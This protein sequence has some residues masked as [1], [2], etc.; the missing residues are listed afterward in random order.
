MIIHKKFD[1]DRSNI[2]SQYFIRVYISMVIL[3]TISLLS[4]SCAVSDTDQKDQ[5]LIISDTGFEKRLIELGIDSEGT[6]DQQLL[7]IDAKT[8]TQLD[9]SWTNDSEVIRDLTGIEGFVN[10]TKLAVTRQEVEQIDL[11]SNIQLDT[12]YL[13]GNNL[14]HIDLSFN[15]NLT[16]VNLGTN[17]LISV[18]GLSE[19]NKLKKLDLSLNY[20]DTFAI[21]NTSVETLF[22]NLNE[23]QSLDVSEAENLKSL[24]LTSNQLTNLSIHNNTKLETLLI[25]NNR[26]QQLELNQNPELQY[27][28]ASN[29]AFTNLDVSHNQNLMDLRIDQNPSLNCIT[30]G[31]AQ[32][33]LMVRKSA[34]QELRSDCGEYKK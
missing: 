26:M 31:Q 28:Y 16:D 18:E 9:I 1:W 11:R 29:N 30:I 21:S 19:L 3:S 34:H 14:Q 32:E 17:G 8:V 24:I 27:L 7:K 13:P 25:S 33:I 4:V 20:L 15:I 5:Y 23:L 22:L 12:L 2:N 6:L 10:L